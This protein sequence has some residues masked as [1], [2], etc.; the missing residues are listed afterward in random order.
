MPTSVPGTAE[1]GFTL[2][3]LM[4]V[5]AIFGFVSAAVVLTMPDLRGSVT[6]E[7][8]RLAARTKAAQDQA[9]IDGR[10]TALRFDRTGYVFERRSGGEWAPFGEGRA[11]ETGTEVA[12]AEGRVLFD[13]AGFAEPM[14]LTLSRGRDRAAVEIGQDGRPHV[15]R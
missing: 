3:E 6:A 12:P 9:V 4:V 11:W 13:S 1:R 7:A 2:V 15:R 14:R 8:E 5:L 10:A